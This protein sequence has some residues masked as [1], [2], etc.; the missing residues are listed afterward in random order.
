MWFWFFVV[1]AIL[2]LLAVFYVRWLIKTISVINEDVSNLSQLIG[3]FSAH[4]KS[5]YELEMFYGDETL[6][7]LMV[8]ASDLTGKL[9]D[10]D[11]VLNEEE[12]E[13]LATSEN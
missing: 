9:A 7:P 11:L 12:G 5:V 2:N 3:E 4:T 6:K 13:E 1:S 8:H 10:L